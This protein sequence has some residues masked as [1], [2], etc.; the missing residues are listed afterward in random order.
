VVVQ[1]VGGGGALTGIVQLTAGTDH[2]CALTTTGEARC[3]GGNSDGQLGNGT[4]TSSSTPVTVQSV[5]G[6]SPLTVTTRVAADL[7][8]TCSTLANGQVVCWG[9][10]ASGQL[11]NGSFSDS[12][13]PVVVSGIG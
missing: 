6:G 4:T 13:L 5:A 2:T 3:W 10:G 11:G 1:Q 8:V 7:Q 12:G 9:R